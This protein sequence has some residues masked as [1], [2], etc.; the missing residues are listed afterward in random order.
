MDARPSG[1]NAITAP[2]VRGYLNRH[3]TRSLS[4]DSLY[5]IIY[6]KHE[7]C[8]I[9]T[10]AISYVELFNNNLTYFTVS[11]IRGVVNM[12][13][14]IVFLVLSVGFSYI[15][16]YL[17]Y[18]IWFHGKRNTYLKIF[19]AMGLMMSV[20]A[21]FNGV[22]PL[23][24][25]EMYVQI[26]PY[27]MLIGCIIPAV[28][29][30]YVLHFTESGLASSRALITILIVL[31]AI[32]VGVLLT[33]PLHHE[34]IAGYDGHY[35]VVG[36]WFLVHALFSYIP[37]VFAVLLLIRYIIRN[38][39]YTPLL[40]GVAVAVIL[41]LVTSILYSF[42]I[43]N[44]GFDTTPLFF[45]VM[46]IIFSIY[47]T[48]FRL[49]DNRSAAFVSLFNTFSEAL[50]VLDNSGHISDANQSFKT[51]FPS[52]TLEVDKTPV[53]ELADYFSSIVI[54]QNPADA[55]DRLG[56]DSDEIVN[57]EITLRQG[58]TTYYYVLTKSGVYERMQHVGF[59]VS[60]IDISNNQRTLQ[61]IEEIKRNNIQLQELKDLS[62]SANQAKSDFL[63]NMSHEI[64]TPMNAIMGM[65]AIGKSAND[66]ERT[67]YALGKIEDASVHLLGVINDILDMSKIEAGKFE[68]SEEEFSIEKMLDRVVNVISF[69]VNEK[70]QKFNLFIDQKLPLVFIGD[71]QRL[72]QV[73]TN[74]LGNAAKFT[75]IEGMVS[76]NT[77]LVSEDDGVCEVRVEV[78]D[79]G[80]GIS[81]EQQARLFQSFQQA[82][83]GTSRKFGG[84]GLG[85]SISKS[86]VEM[87]GGR[88]WVESELGKG[89]TFAFTIKMRRGDLQRYE[90]SNKETNWKG[91]RI[92][93]IDDNSGILGYIKNFV[94]SYGAVC[95]TAVC[96][97]DAMDIVHKNGAY[98]LYFI[99]WKLADIDA[100]RL[101][102]GLKA[103]EP[104]KSK[105][106]ITMVSSLEWGDLQEDAKNAGVDVFLPKPLFPSALVD[107]IN[108][109]IGAVASP[110]SSS[111]SRAD[112][113]RYDFSAHTILIAEDVEINREILSAL[114]EETGIVIDY[115]ENGKIAVSMFEKQPGSYGL[116]LMDIQM[117]EMEGYEAAR[118]IRA[119][120]ADV[121][122]IAMTANVFREDV[123]QCLAAGMNDHVGKPIDI[124][125]LLSKMN[126]YLIINGINEHEGAAQ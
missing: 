68:L 32:D 89:A 118:A 37:L 30:M 46:F 83:S 113:S 55:I 12:E 28:F 38:I 121:P 42:D 54:E 93:V 19:F 36:K 60:L 77:K 69:R 9:S 111:Q 109:C 4:Y 52:V 40:G 64:R 3:P 115:A 98:D 21:L 101:T 65:T 24:S 103:I 114:L 94:E 18:R 90:Q 5:L 49:F 70:K 44:F 34:F 107:T 67:K 59:I 6:T 110:A 14:R 88:I 50:L 11:I 16:T 116:I 61:M 58:E 85:L 1:R 81:P 106:V 99:D 123:E 43:L 78:T 124:K 26:C 2:E 74:L 48:R 35:P 100:L 125:E 7:M 33:N 8:Y 71:D 25:Q 20:W 73:I 57:A 66:I 56:S 62:E 47:S 91:I 79:S 82:E 112:E 72:A 108:G 27:Y 23:L 45:L 120:S 117:P 96:G 13:T 29:L 122:I 31:A 105:I 92:L 75:P 10:K 95:D 104:D 87:M 53:S 17:V 97:A 41:P 76:L 15:D 102:R 22:L 51:M 80:I 63:A 84:T 86:I 126:Q 39:K 119:K